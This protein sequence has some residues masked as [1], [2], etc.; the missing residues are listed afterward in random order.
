[1]DRAAAVSPAYRGFDN[2]DG[3]LISEDARND[4]YPG[5]HFGASMQP[6]PFTAGSS[7]WMEERYPGIYQRTSKALSSEFGS[8]AVRQPS[9]LPSLFARLE[10]E[11]FSTPQPVNQYSTTYSAYDNYMTHIP[12]CSTYPLNY[13]QSMP[14]VVAS[15]EVCAATKSSLPTTDGHILENPF[16]SPYTNPCRLNLDYFDTMQNEQKDLFG[17]QTAYNKHYGDWSNPNNGTRIVGNYP[18]GTSGVGQNYLL[19]DC[20]ETGGPVHPSSEVKTGLKC[21]KPLGN[22]PLSRYGVGENYLGE[23]S[24]TVGSVPVQP[25][26]EVESGLKHTG[27]VGN[28]PL[29]RR[30]AGENY[31]L[32]ESSETGRP[33]QPSSEVKSDLK[34]LQ[35]SCSKVS[36][37]HPFTHPRDLFT[38]SLE[39]NNPV[40]DSPC[41]KG[42]P[43]LQQPSFDGVKND[44]APYSA[45]GSGDLHDLQQGKKLSEFSIN[46]SVLFPN[47][48]DT[49]NPEDN[50]CVPYFMNYLSA[51][52]LPSE[53]KKVGV[54]C[55]AQP[56]IVEDFS[57]M[58]KSVEQGNRSDKHL[59]CKTRDDFG[60]QQSVFPVNENNGPMVL[61]RKIGSHIGCPIEESSK[62]VSSNV[63]AAPT[64]LIRSLTEESLQGNTFVHKPAATLEHLCS[65][66][67]MNKGLEHLTHH[68]S[69]VEEDLRKISGDRITSRSKTRAEFI[70]SMYDLSAMLLSTCNGGYEL[71]ESEHA[72][73]QSV[74]QNLSSLSSKISKAAFK[75]DDVNN[76]CCKMNLEKVKCC[77][78]TCQSKKFAGLDGGNIGAD[79]KTFL[80][81]DLAKL[82]EENVVSDS[83]DAQMLVYKNLWIEAEASVCKLKYELQLTRM[84]PA[85]KHH[86][87]QTAAA[88]AVSFGEAKV[89]NLPKFEDSLCIG[90]IDDSSKHK[91]QNSVKESNIC[92]ATLLPQGG[93]EVDAAVFA[94]LKV[95][96]LR[97]ESINGFHED[98]S[99]LP[100]ETS[101][102]DT[103]DVDGADMHNEVDDMV[104]SLVEDII[105][106]RLETSRRKGDE[107]DG[108]TIGALE[109]FM[110]YNNTSSLDEETNQEELESSKSKTGCAMARLEDLMCCNDEI[111]SLSGGNAYLVQ[112]ASDDK[113]GQ[114]ED[115]VM[116]RLQVLKRRLDNT[117]SV[118][119]VGPKVIRSDDWADLFESKE[120]GRVAHDG[121]IEKTDMPDDVK[122]RTRSG[123]ANGSS[124]VQYL[125]ALPQ[126]SQVLSAPVEPAALH[127]HDEQFSHSPS[128]WE[129]VLKEDFFLPGKPLK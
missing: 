123:E 115:G 74:I 105:N 29:S 45:N 94:R 122:C 27:L 6:H 125:G 121:L 111:S 103:T 76:N 96:K 26:S 20:S 128:E 104:I 30:G 110:S 79:F 55:D 46:N 109:D 9:V 97:D 100:K 3:F 18:L 2:S 102:Y 21:M 101:S 1:M 19:G 58:T 88:P 113:S 91:E 59:S 108:A 89:S 68:N 57:G 70:K 124:T 39:L 32:G 10:K 112:T 61:G 75:V 35:A 11:P 47:L 66:I 38:D 56:S 72:L 118:V 7:E 44:E 84:K 25:S 67:P 50:P 80:I 126:E 120:S 34:S 78:K 40:V 83:E 117:S 22:Y 51:F 71:E 82:Q 116:A 14:P 92:S 5:N 37:E 15:P 127:L 77:G 43:T 36:P 119:D 16:S 12:S 62:K 53:S 85:M 13:D 60:G 33:V 114:L 107:A 69:G 31:L 42:T 129:H 81:Q 99:E 87:Q 52:S 98:G 73:V 63:G 54:H 4:I 90:E 28:Y 106:K 23:N 41:W 65:E 49:S 86:H 24:E 8:S 48:H 17:Y 93:D 64:A 95:L